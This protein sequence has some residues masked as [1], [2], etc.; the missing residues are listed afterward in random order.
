MP[1]HFR[2]HQATENKELA[3][4]KCGRPPCPAGSPRPDPIATRTDEAQH[5]PARPWRH[6]HAPVRRTR[7]RD[8]PDPVRDHRRLSGYP[9]RR[10]RAAAVPEARDDRRLP[11]PPRRR[12]SAAVPRLSGAAPPDPRPHQGRHP[13]CAHPGTRRGGGPGDLDELEMR[14]GRP[15][16]WRRQ[17]RDR[18]RPARAQP[19]RA[20]SPV[21]TLHAGDDPLRRPLHRRD[22]PGHGHQ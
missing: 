19:A 20:G 12:T 15:A 9:C 2:D 3:S 1:S 18:G 10:T 6:R 16:V 13:L 7:V 11:D 17:G 21:A 4:R 8:G 14:A 22:G 5:D